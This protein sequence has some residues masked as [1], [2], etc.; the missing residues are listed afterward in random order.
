MV[1]ADSLDM[2]RRLLL[3]TIVTVV[4]CGGEGELSWLS[5]AGGKA[6]GFTIDKPA[7]ADLVRGG[8]DRTS[9]G[10]AFAR[11]GYRPPAGTHLLAAKVETGVGQPA[12]SFFSLGE[13]GFA[14]SDGRYWPASTVKLMAAVGALRTMRS[15]SVTGAARVRFD[16][17][18]GRYEGT[19]RE[20]YK[21]ALTVS[22]NVAYNR[23]MEIAG[24]D[25]LN[26]QY[27]DEA[28]LTRTVL[29]RRYTHPTP[30]ADL[31]TSP[32][33]IFNEGISSGTIERFS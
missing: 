16:D 9:L 20:L 8:A 3:V 7:W 29:Q 28:G 14:Y 4:G 17:P 19:V 21:A 10:D 5:G 11:A 12:Y 13:S 23:L 1:F 25:E 32:P 6:D 27:L 18:D 30:E 26:E 31:R 22:S 33:I 24:F 2:L 15:Y